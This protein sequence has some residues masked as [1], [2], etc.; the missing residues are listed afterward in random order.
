MFN[1]NLLIE[2]LGWQSESHKE[3]EQI[4]PTLYNHLN[5]IKSKYSLV[6]EQDTH[7]NIFVTKGKA[8]LYPCIV[9]HLDQVHKYSENKTIIEIDDYL[10]AFNGPNQIGTGGDDLVGVFICLSLLEV[11]DKIKVVF[12]IAEEVGCVGSNACDLSF[13]KDCKFIGQ[14]DRR[15]SSDFINHSNG[16]KLFD[17]EFSQFVKKSLDLYGYKECGGTSTD[18]GCLSKRR[19]NI[20]CFNIS[21]GYYL[22]HSSKEYVKI[23]DVQ[24]CYNVI[25]NIIDNAD[26]QFVYIRPESDYKSVTNNTKSKLYTMLYEEFRNS[27]RYIKSNNMNY[28]YSI[29][30]QFFEDLLEKIDKLTDV[31]NSDYPYV[32][33]MLYEY[34]EFF[35]EER[36]NEIELKNESHL[37]V[38]QTSIFDNCKHKSTKYDITMD[39]TYCMDCF[40][41]I[42][43]HEAYYDRDTLNSRMGN[44]Y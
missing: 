31:Y 36:E 43:E 35:Q 17:N 19:V 34:L 12:F 29:T 26:K 25:L 6:I 27:P 32:S 14:A 3:K 37:N 18:A 8:D 40:Q 38:R 11:V 5:S 4:I 22:P 30:I 44:V 16:V 9:S 21:C 15:D 28:A 33:D 23:S 42:D 24:R 1:K 2:V 10:L 7:G 20:A 41:Y 13:F 39:K